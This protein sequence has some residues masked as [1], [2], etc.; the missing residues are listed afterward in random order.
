MNSDMFK[1]WL[2]QLKKDGKSDR[3]IG[4]MV[5]GVAKLSAA[6]VYMALMTALTEE[7]IQAVEKIEDDGEAK[8]K[9]EEFFKLRTRMTV[10]EFIAKAQEEFA[11]GYLKS[12][13]SP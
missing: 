12:Q 10:E 9:M 4:E 11:T 3:E 7:D 8:N 5:A 1:K 13:S 6:G 2:E